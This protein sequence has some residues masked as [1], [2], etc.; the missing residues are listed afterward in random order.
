LEL[1]AAGEKPSIHHICLRI[2]GF[3]R[4]V[5]MEK[6]KRIDVESAVSDEGLLRFRDPNG[7]TM[8]LKGES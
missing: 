6:L 2:A 4:K 1:A 5:A 8:E 7:M 3:D